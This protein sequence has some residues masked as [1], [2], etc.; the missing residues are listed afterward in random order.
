[1]KQCDLSCNY[2]DSN[3]PYS[4]T[5][6]QYHIVLLIEDKLIIIL[7]VFSSFFFCLSTLYMKQ[8]YCQ[9]PSANISDFPSLCVVFPVTWYIKLKA[10]KLPGLILFSICAIPEWLSALM[11]VSVVV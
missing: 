4:L 9:P 6:L 10:S 2:F 8:D 5:S 1:M 3:F 7:G 11:P